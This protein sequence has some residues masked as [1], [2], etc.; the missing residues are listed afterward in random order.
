MTKG[1]KFEL[2]EILH[3]TRGSGDGRNVSQA[4]DCFAVRA[5]SCLQWS[6]ILQMRSTCILQLLYF[7]LLKGECSLAY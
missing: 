3:I 7:E 5:I 4:P 6:Y 2:W 1:H